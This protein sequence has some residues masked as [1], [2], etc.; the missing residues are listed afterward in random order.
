MVGVNTLLECI[1]RHSMDLFADGAEVEGGLTQDPLDSEMLIVV[2]DEDVGVKH[3]E[4][5]LDVVESGLVKAF[6]KD[7]GYLL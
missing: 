4:V 3:I 2:L 7:D 1:R 5:R 6:E